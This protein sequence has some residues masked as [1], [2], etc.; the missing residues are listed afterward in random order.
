VEG[1]GNLDEREHLEFLIHPGA[2][3]DEYFYRIKV[4]RGKLPPA[5]STTD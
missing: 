5:G 4:R 2:G 1:P 3:F